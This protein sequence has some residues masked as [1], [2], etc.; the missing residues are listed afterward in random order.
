MFEIEIFLFFKKNITLIG[1][2]G[3]IKTY[4]CL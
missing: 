3:V 4:I 1:A 2:F